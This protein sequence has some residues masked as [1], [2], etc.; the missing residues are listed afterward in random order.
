MTCRYSKLNHTIEAYDKK[1]ELL[2]FEVNI[3][4]G[5]IEQLRKIMNWTKPEDEIYGYDLDSQ[6]IT[7]LENLIGTEFFDPQFDFQ[8]GC[9]GSN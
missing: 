2:V 8:L 5:N 7:E 1:T 4:D 6:K 9:Y 3:P